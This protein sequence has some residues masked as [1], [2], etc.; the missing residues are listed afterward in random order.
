MFPTQ[1]AARDQERT[2]VVT[3]GKR[4]KAGGRKKR[5][6]QLETVKMGEERGKRMEGR[7]R[8]ES[9]FGM[10]NPGFSRLRG[11]HNPLLLTLPA[12]G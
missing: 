8:N 10:L 4:S 9:N 11:K 12:H 6:R 5:K 2:T 1:T 7:E 3:R